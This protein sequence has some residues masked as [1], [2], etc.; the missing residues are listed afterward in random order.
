[1]FS[2]T[3][4]Y[5]YIVNHTS[6]M[7]TWLMDLL[8]SSACSSFANYSEGESDD[9]ILSQHSPATR[10]RDEDDRLGQVSRSPYILSESLNKC[11]T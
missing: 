2:L 7:L 4:C 11:Q 10:M 1:M 3:L 9:T 8:S 5:S 6:F